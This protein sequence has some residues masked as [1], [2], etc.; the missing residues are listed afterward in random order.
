MSKL[1]MSL[2][3]NPFC[4][5]VLISSSNTTICRSGTPYLGTQGYGSFPCVGAIRRR[6]N[7]LP[8]SC[9]RPQEYVSLTAAHVQMD[10]TEV[11]HLGDRGR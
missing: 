8:P 4:L 6:C 2:A 1:R 7:K 10:T 9:H 3:P 11:S 5:L